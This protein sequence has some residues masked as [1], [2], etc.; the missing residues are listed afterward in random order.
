[1]GVDLCL[2]RPHSSS[3]I[4]C[5]LVAKAGEIAKCDRRSG[6]GVVGHFPCVSANSGTAKGF[7]CETP[8]RLRFIPPASYL[9]LLCSL[10]QSRLVLTDSGGIQEETTALG[11]SARLVLTLR[12]NTDRP[13]TVTEGTNQLVG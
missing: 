8:L 4:Q 10:D 6:A 5:G 7:T 11:G 2:F 3:A 13:V 12:G 9:D 1:M